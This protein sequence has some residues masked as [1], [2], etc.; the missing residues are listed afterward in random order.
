[1]AIL[2]VARMGHPVLRRV[3][4]PFTPEEIR[5]EATRRLVA[6]MLDT[7]AEYDGAGLAAPQVH[8]SRRLMI[9]GVDQNPRYPDAEEVPVT[10]LFNPSWEKVGDETYEDWEGCLSLPDLRGKVRRFQHIKVKALDLD[11]E[12]LEFTADDFHARVFQH[13][14]DHLDGV[15]FVDRMTDFKELFFLKEWYRY[16]LGEAYPVE[17]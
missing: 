7:M 16:G 8:V 2:K 9:Y 1:M 13:E 3:A 14:Y 6:D 11:G 10:V 5:S 12:E 17:E 4:E 15:L